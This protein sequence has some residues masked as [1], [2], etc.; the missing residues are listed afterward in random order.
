LSDAISMPLLLVS[1]VIVIGA[2]AG[3]VGA[4]RLAWTVRLL[5]GRP[6]FRRLSEA[7]N[8]VTRGGG[9]ALLSAKI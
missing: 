7:T 3:R 8:S 2:N 1:I 6:A 5:P 9:A 4:I